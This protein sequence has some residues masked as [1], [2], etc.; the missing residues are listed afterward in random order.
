MFSGCTNLSDINVAFI[1]WTP[2]NI[3]EATA[4]WVKG[5]QT[6]AGT[7]TKP[8]TLSTTFGNNY[9]PTNWTVTNK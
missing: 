6:T 5:V 4:D 7:F 9:I 2:F 8:S 3:N 1:K